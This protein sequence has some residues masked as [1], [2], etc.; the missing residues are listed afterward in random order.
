[1][2]NNLNLV[3]VILLFVV[4]G[5]TCPPPK[6]NVSTEKTNYPDSATLREAV[7]KNIGKYPKKWGS[8]SFTEMS[9]NHVIIHLDYTAMPSSMAEVETDTKRI[10]KAVL[11]ALRS[12]GYDPKANWFEL[13]VHAQKQ[14]ANRM[15]R[16]FGK[17]MYDFN[18]DTLTFSEAGSFY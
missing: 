2:K 1:M 12:L 7:K 15:V 18:N 5:C 3:L 11:D 4:I 9:N 16:R 6:E 17:T 14:E 10:A 13:F 8:V